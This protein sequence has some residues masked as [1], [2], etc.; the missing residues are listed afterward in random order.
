M[1]KGINKYTKRSYYGDV[2][3]DNYNCSYATL[4]QEIRHRTL[5]YQIFKFNGFNCCY[6]PKIIKHTPYENEWINDYNNL[7]K[8][9]TIS[10]CTLV[11]I[12]EEGRFED[13]LLKAKERLCSRSQ[14]EICDIT[15][16]QVEKFIFHNN[17]LCYQNKLLLEN[18]VSTNIFERDNIRVLP[19]CKTCGYTC[20]E[21]C[22]Q[23]DDNVLYN[24]IV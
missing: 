19:K 6:I 21:P 12:I 17:N 22:K 9:G 10:Q 16:H 2:Y 20:K 14:L 4:A 15:R 3:V 5:H 18:M 13:W 24:R 1:A 8:N 11:D 23:C 7:I